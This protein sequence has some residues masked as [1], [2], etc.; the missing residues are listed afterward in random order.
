MLSVKNSKAFQNQHNESVIN[1]RMVD[2]RMPV[3]MND[4][5]G[6]SGLSTKIDDID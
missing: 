4:F 6:V 2:N 3:L 5:A 1:L